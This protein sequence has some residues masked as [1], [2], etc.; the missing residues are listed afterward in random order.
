MAGLS[1]AE[2]ERRDALLVGGKKRCTGPRGCGE[3]K[4][5]EEFRKR[6][7]GYAGRRSEC[8]ECE[9][10]AEAA[11]RAEHRDEEL[12]R[13]QRYWAEQRFGQRLNSGAVRARKRGVPAAGV[14]VDAL[15][16]DWERRGIDPSRDAYTGEPLREGWHLDHVIPL[17]APGT[18]GHVVSNIVPCNAETNVQK[19]RRGWVDFLADRAEIE[20]HEAA[21][22]EGAVQAPREETAA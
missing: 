4:P 12:E 7:D 20:R 11:W 9:Q 2:R 13:I 16:V 21:T 14:T 22:P 5:L 15:L 10:A 3:A 18:P 1:R 6:R 17:S 19:N 8:I